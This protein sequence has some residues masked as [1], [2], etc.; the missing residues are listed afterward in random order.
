MSASQQLP[1]AIG[2]RDGSTFE[3]FLAGTANAEALDAVTRL[4]QGGHNV[5]Y[6]C[7]ETGTGRSHLLQACVHAATAAGRNVFYLGLAGADRPSPA[8]LE[9]LAESAALV[10]LDDLDAVAGDSDWE[11]ALFHLYN[12]L[13]ANGGQL[14]VAAATVPAAAGWCLAD[15]VSR[16]N[17][18]LV[19][20]LAV[21]SDEQRV[22]IIAFR[23]ARR[24]LELSPETGRYLLARVQ[25]RLDK[26]MTVLDRL[27]REAMA[28]QRRLSIPFVRQVLQAGE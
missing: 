11:E 2:L 14:L 6:L 13:R 1:L 23:A 9:G 7:G 24:G 22:D 17:S 15:L 10:C 16:L 3:N 21:P 26:L 20:R 12:S 25:R 27:D 18:A 8:V 4:L 28:H 19:I 5:V